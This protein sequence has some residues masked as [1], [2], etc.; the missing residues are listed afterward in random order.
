MADY[1]HELAFGTFITP[2]NERPDDVV[3]L[4]RLTERAGLDLV[5]FQDHPYQP[6]S[7]TPGRCS[8]GSPRRRRRCR[9]RRTCSTC[10]CGRLRWSRA[11]RRASTCSPAAAS[12]SASA[13]APSGTRSRRW[14]ARGGHRERAVDALS[15][16]IDVI[17]SIWDVSERGGVRVDGEHYRVWGAKRG[18][19]PA[20]DISI[21]LGARKPRMLQLTGAKADGWIPPSLPYLLEGDFEGD[22]ERGN[23]TI[24]E[25]ATG[26]GRDPREVRRLLNI[27]GTF[28]TT[29][30]GF[31]QGPQ[32]QWVE[33]LL[34]LVLEHGFSTFILMADDPR[35][36][37]VYGQEV[38]PAL[39][40]AVARERAAV[41]TPPREVV[42]GPK[43]L[44]LRRDGIDYD[45]LPESLATKAIEPGDKGYASV[46][47]TYIRTG[48][49]GLV[50]QPEGVDDVIAALAF[51]R[52]QEVPL[53]IR[54]GGHGISGRSTNDGG[55]VIDLG[56]LDEIDVST[57]RAGGS[58]SARARAGATW[59]RRSPR[60]ASR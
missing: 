18:P 12:S 29:N 16:A 17:R 52:E 56:R 39:R 5:T 11:R 38:A 8:R 32:E 13:P 53:A 2:L 54:S 4:A 27:A 45:A 57:R 44:A 22:L 35:T 51:A 49:P 41:G 15:E 23:R 7:S 55:I 24:D 37:E 21:W 19:E 20:H 58:A 42:R 43:A 50:I 14:A 1:G 30:G 48:A 26:E 3:A 34:P 36:I 28:A 9:C 46:R 10:R 40:E 47:S 59:R 31:L 25:A 60:T 6:G 33:E